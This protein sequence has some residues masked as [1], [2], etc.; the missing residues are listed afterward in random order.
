MKNHLRTTKYNRSAPRPL[1]GLRCSAS[2][3]AASVGADL[4]MIKSTDLGARLI[5]GFSVSKKLFLRIYPK[6]EI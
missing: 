2:R 5:F 6:L 4:G 1:R 3:L